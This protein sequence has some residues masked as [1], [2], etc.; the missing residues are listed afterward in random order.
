LVIRVFDVKEGGNLPGSRENILRMQS[1]MKDAASVL[2]LP[3]DELRNRLEA[4]RGKLF[5]A[6]EMRVH[7]GRD[8]KILAD[9]NG[10]IIAALAKAAVAMND[11]GYAAT[12]RRAADFILSNMRSDEG[13]LSHVYGAGSGSVSNL[14]DYAFMVWGLIEL[15]QATFELAYLQ[16][17]LELTREGIEH[18]W[19]G[20]NGGF[21][22]TPDYG[23]KLLMRKK[24]IYDGAV[25]SGNSVFMYNLLRLSHLTGD[26]E[27]EKRAHEVSKAFSSEVRG[28]PAAYA[29][30][31]LAVDFAVGPSYE[32][33]IVG[34]LGMPDT[35]DMLRELGSGFF[36]R[37]V[38]LFLTPEKRS[39]VGALAT[40]AKG[41]SSEGGMATAYVCS[42]HTCNL[43]ITDI[44]KMLELICEGDPR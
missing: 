37:M 14:D 32:V 36:P 20:Y 13:R 5:A 44:E 42:N 1:S 40:F 30:L 34:G 15:Y 9:W 4:V 11:T 43:P 10:L 33:A 17:A 2:K 24:E 22:F 18:F 28:R 8:E 41:F 16:S 31:M 38:V 39:D 27:M 21:Y 12:A 6:R 19:D 7:P 25:P 35:S 26:P 3:E 23:E 29:M